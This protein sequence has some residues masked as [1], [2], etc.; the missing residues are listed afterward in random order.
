MNTP[1]STPRHGIILAALLLAAAVITGAFGAHGL[2]GKL[3]EKALE[4]YHTGVTYHFYHAFGLLMLSLW[5]KAFSA[6]ASAAKWF[7]I[8]GILLFSFNCY[9]Y[10]LSSIKTFAMIVPIGGVCFILGWIAFAVSAF[11][12]ES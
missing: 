9:F 10:A 1:L 11:K 3:S 6:K 4:T 2:E 8:L 7:F 12:K 5:E